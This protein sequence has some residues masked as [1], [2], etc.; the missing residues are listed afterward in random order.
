MRTPEFAGRLNVVD[1]GK[2]PWKVIARIRGEDA[3][4]YVG[5]RRRLWRSYS[6]EFIGRVKR[7]REEVHPNYRHEDFAEAL[8][9]VMARAEQRANVL[10]NWSEG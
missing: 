2:G 4:V 6:V 9:R 1:V 8:H 3:Y 7:N 10:N 5:K